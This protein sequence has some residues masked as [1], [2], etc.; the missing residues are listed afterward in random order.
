MERSGAETTPAIE[1]Q[2]VDLS[3]E[4]FRLRVPSPLED[5]A[6]ITVRIRTHDGMDLTLA[7]TVRWQRAEDDAW[8][9]GCVA[10]RP[11]DWE[12]LGELFLHNVLN[13]DGHPFS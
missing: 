10:D 13:T 5:R 11:T 1:A 7:G 6:P 2:L 12:T 8:L 4:G 9:V 3:R